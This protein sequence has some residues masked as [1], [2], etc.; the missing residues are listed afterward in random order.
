MLAMDT[1]PLRSTRL[2]A[3]SF[4]IIASM[5]APTEGVGERCNALV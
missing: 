4:T 1:R 3:L 2:P 5:L